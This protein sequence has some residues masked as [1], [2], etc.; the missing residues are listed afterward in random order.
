M[1]DDRYVLDLFAGPGGWDIAAQALDIDPIG[2]E[3]DPAACRTRHAAGLLTVNASV[4]AIPAEPFA[5]R[6]AGLIAS[7]PC[8]TFSQAGSGA[9]RS[10]LPELLSFVDEWARTGWHDPIRWHGWADPR[11]PLVL[12]P[13]RFIS[14]AHPEWVVLEQVPPVADLWAHYARALRALGWRSAWAGVLNAA[15]YGVPQTRKRA[16]LIAHRTEV[17]TP[18]E[19]T[20]AK[21]PTPS[22]FGDDLH[23]WVTMADALGWDP[24]C[25]LH[26]DQGAGMVDRHGSRPPRV[27]GRDPAFGLTGDAQ[28]HLYVL[29]PGR[30][31][32]QPNRRH[33]DPAAEPAPTVAFGHDAAGWRWAPR[34][35]DQSGHGANPDWPRERPATTIAGRDLV[36][37]P[38]ANANRHNDSEKSR[39]DGFRITIEEAL[40]LQ[41]FPPD[42]PVAGSK[43]QQ[44][45][46]VGNAVPPLLAIHILG[47]VL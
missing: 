20:H 34:R 35:N 42:Y 3:L 21:T 17:V 10:E 29:N 37:D 2:V 45:L 26:Q 14:T 28:R 36:A 32:S 31:A 44:F 30:T 22:L 43:S 40:V 38:G 16:I 15:D 18:P 33:Y 1:T 41:S 11:T 4:P 7:P 12:E 13:L 19:P 5:G 27:S 25:E 39:N 8:P 46:Q 23:P 6:L 24:A 47:S 9:G